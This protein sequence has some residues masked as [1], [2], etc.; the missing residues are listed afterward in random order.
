[1]ETELKLFKSIC[2]GNDTEFWQDDNYIT[3]KLLIDRTWYETKDEV[4]NEDDLILNNDF[5]SIFKIDKIVLTELG[6]RDYMEVTRLPLLNKTILKC[7]GDKEPFKFDIPRW[8]KL[9]PLQT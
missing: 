2:H 3:R 6:N 1:M 7:N 5:N 8:Y 4:Y 9:I